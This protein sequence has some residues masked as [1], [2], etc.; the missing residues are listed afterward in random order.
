MPIKQIKI[1]NPY[2]VSLRHTV[3]SHGWVNLPPWEWDEDQGRLA[4]TQL[5]LSSVPSQIE[6]VQTPALTFQVTVS[7]HEIRPTDT[8]YVVSTINR[9]LSLDW[10]HTPAINIASKV[11]PSVATFIREGGGRFL[12]GSTFYEDF[13][14]TVCTVQINWSGTKRMVRALIDEIGGGFL[15]APRQM[16]DA[17]EGGLREKAR[18]GFR[19]RGLVESTERLLECCLIDEWG[20][21]EEDR[22]TYEELIALRGVGPYAASHLRVLLRDF[23]RI[24]VDSEVT[25]YCREQLGLAPSEIEPYFDRW[26]HYRFIGF[27]Y[28]ST[29]GS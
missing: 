3:R 1:E 21:G 7:A 26:E 17:G 6:V 27:R 4:R 23:S 24:P 29:F 2:N 13:V 18:L 25:R 11:D 12:R 22:L 16:I 19:A 10:D 14:K 5:L 20:N 9:W 15:P 28:G 8:S